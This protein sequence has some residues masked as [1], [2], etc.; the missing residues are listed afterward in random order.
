MNEF[1]EKCKACKRF[2]RNCSIL[3]KAKEGRI[4][5][6][7]DGELNCSKFNAK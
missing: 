7:I 6:E 4:Q 2:A 1:E 5:E 3:N